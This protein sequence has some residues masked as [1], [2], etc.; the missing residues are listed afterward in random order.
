[1]TFPGVER[2]TRYMSTIDQGIEAICAISNSSSS[3]LIRTE[4]VL[5]EESPLLSWKWKIT[6]IYRTADPFSRTGDDFPARLFV[7][8][9]K[10]AEERSFFG[11]LKHSLIH[12]FP[13]APPPEAALAYVWASATP[14]GSIIPSP[15]TDR[16]R[17]LVVES[18]PG[19][20]GR[21]MTMRRNVVADYRKVFGNDPPPIAGIAIMTDSD[22]TGESA[23]SFYGRIVFL[24]AGSDG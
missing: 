12:L 21:W 18:G 6:K 10:P 20:L 4:R 19:R 3:G 24:T 14:I 2:R 1:M 7:I 15:Y 23:M 11:K 16:C 8:F 22:N 13:G 5:P 9:D 17:A